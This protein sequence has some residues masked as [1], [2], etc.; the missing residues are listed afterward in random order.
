[1]PL[2]EIL[3]AVFRWMYRVPWPFRRRKIGGPER[4]RLDLGS[5]PATIEAERLKITIGAENAAIARPSSAAA[6]QKPPRPRP[7]R[8]RRG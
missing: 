5:I 8:R 3:G 7:R 1:M 6:K 4:H 2:T